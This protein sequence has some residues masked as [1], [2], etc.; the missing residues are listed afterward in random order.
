MNKVKI[1]KI[2]YFE[3]GSPPPENSSFKDKM[4]AD[5]L[6]G[7][8]NYT[9]RED[10]KDDNKKLDVENGYFSYTSSHHFSATRTSEG[11]IENNKDRINFQKRYVNISIMTVI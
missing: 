6:S 7:Y 2:R 8:S 11:I 5:S 1:D 4:S 10:A 3:C 9:G